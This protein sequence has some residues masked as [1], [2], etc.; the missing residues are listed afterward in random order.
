MMPFS[1][2]LSRIVLGF[3]LCLALCAPARTE[4]IVTL[5]TQQSD[6][7]FYRAIACGAR[8]G[9]RCTTT[10]AKWP[11]EKRKNLTVGIVFTD[12]SFDRAQKNNIRKNLRAAI[13]EIN[14]VKS[15]VRLKMTNYT[16]PDIRVY[17]VPIAPISQVG[18]VRGTQDETVDGSEFGKRHVARVDVFWNAKTKNSPSASITRANIIYTSRMS[19]GETKSVVLEELVQSLG[20][21]ADIDGPYYELR[22]IFAENANFVTQLD[23]QDVSTLRMH[24]PPAK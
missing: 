14:S 2:T 12:P 1:K 4:T 23:G 9:K 13:R 5:K 20:L 21:L 3:G 16:Y 10:L 11:A 19:K 22:S 24:Y 17:L 18:V 15:S 6:E 8:P 7:N